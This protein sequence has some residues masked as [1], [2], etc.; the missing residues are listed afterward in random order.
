MTQLETTLARIPA[1]YAELLTASTPGK[2]AE[3]SDRSK[4]P[5]DKPAPG[6]LAVMEHRALLLRGLRWHVARA[7]NVL[8]LGGRARVGDDPARACAWLEVYAVDL[9]AEFREELRRDLREWLSRAWGLLDPAPLEKGETLTGRLPMGAWEQTVTVATAAEVLGCT[10]RTI[11]R[12][13]PAE[14]RPGGRLRLRDAL[15]ACKD[16]GQPVGMCDHTRCEDCG[17]IVG[18]CAHTAQTFAP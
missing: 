9:P 17:L 15:G 13:V 11:Q 3:P 4:D 12:R 1:V 10:V 18:Q 16:C 7:Q 6:S 8:R 2:S 5:R 14:D